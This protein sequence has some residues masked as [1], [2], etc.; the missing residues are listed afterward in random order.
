MCV[1]VFG[2][3]AQVLP[4]LRLA[5]AARPGRLSGPSKMRDLLHAVH[6]HAS[7]GEASRAS[8]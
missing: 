7:G 1:D 4:M 2:P 8:K 3:I 5:I 6:P